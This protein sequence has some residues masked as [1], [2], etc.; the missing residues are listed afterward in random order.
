MFTRPSILR[1]LLLSFI[2]FGLAMGAIFPVFAQFF[3]EWKPGMLLPFV[4]SC[5]VAG[6]MIGLINYTILRLVLLRRL[7]RIADVN[8][9]ITQ[10]DLTHRCNI[11]SHDLIGDLIASFNQMTENLRGMIGQIHDNTRQLSD[12]SDSLVGVVTQTSDRQARQQEATREVVQDMEQIVESIREVAENT[13]QAAGAAS[14]ARAEAADGNRTAGDAMRSIAALSDQMG[15][16]AGA[17]DKVRAENDNIHAVLDVIGEISEQTNLLALNAAIEA[18]RAGENGRGFAVVADEVRKLASRSQTSAKQIKEMLAR[19]NTEVQQA[20]NIMT[21]ASTQVTDSENRVRRASD[22]LA[23]ISTSADGIEQMNRRIAENVD[24]QRQLTEHINHNINAIN[25]N[26]SESAA[27][28]QA[29]RHSTGELAGI[30]DQL[31]NLVGRF[32]L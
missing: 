9:A 26:S 28:M 13:R 10:N 4:V 31:R 1:N 14:E 20:V 15:S 17:I 16:V 23:G 7:R 19:L 3:V 30:S 22:V 24:R 29:A 2:G 32:R 18:A 6:L 12:S 8:Q 21:E 27:E 5:L 25:D 11:Q